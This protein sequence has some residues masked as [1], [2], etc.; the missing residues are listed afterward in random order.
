MTLIAGRVWLL[1]DDVSTD[2]I[3]P[4]RYMHLRSNLE[5]LAKHVLEDVR[6]EFSSEVRQGD[7]VVAGKNFGM[8]SS[9]EHA[10]LLL[11][12][13]GVSAVVARSFARI[14]Y[15]NAINLGLPAVT[16][17]TS[18]LL[19]GDRLEVD[20]ERGTVGVS[21][22]GIELTAQPL[23]RVMLNILE[24]GGVVRHMKKNGGRLRIE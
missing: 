2:L 17:D 3:Q 20:L 23:P 10:P 15:R 14:F 16:C 9:R 6:P 21:V 19:D 8:G 24:D 5:E 7:I 1:G 22:R 4:S 18:R 11:V 12:Q 13:L